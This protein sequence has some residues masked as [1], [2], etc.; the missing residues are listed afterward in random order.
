M[1]LRTKVPGRWGIGDMD[2]NH[3]LRSGMYAIK[4]SWSV[5]RGPQPVGMF[6]SFED[7]APSL[8]EPL[9]S[10]ATQ[11]LDMERPGHQTVLKA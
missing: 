8:W 11:Q 6:A 5:L 2:P 3:R 7:S 10:T 4:K 1:T 9:F